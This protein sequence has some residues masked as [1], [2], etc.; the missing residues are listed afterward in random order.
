MEEKRYHILHLLKNFRRDIPLIINYVRGTSTE[1]YRHTVCYL[2]RNHGYSNALSELV[3]EVI[4]L[5]FSNRSLK[6][7][8][9]YVILKLSAL[10]K[11]RDV[12]ILHC[13]KHKPTFYGTLASLMHAHVS[14]ISHVHGLRRTRTVNRYV[15]NWFLYKHVKKIITVSESVRQ[16]VINTNHT[17]DP[18][19]VVTIKNGIDT[20]VIDTVMISKNNTRSKLGIHG[21]RLVFGTIGRL[22]VTKGQSYLIRAFSEVVKRIPHAMLVIVG[23]GP[24]LNSLRKEAGDTGVSAD[25]LFTGFRNDVYELLK[26]FDIFV[27][28]SIAEGLSIALLEAMTSRLPVIATNVGGIPEVLEHD[29]G[30]LVPAGN[31]GALAEAMIKIALLDKKERLILGNAAR[32]RVIEEFTVDSMTGKMI[33]LYESLVN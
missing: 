31:P 11:S 12:H 21:D 24:L 20:S 28:P 8:N 23:D 30:L 4:Y 1:K 29:S 15:T 7:V 26:E 17:V 9:P 18:E 33:E 19:K 10:L 2:G 14:V 25:V 5:G 13:H 6:Y 3:E 16:D 22:A 27:L 32:Q